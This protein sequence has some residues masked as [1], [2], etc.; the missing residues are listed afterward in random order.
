MTDQT[1]TMPPEQS[2]LLVLN[3]LDRCSWELQLCSTSYSALGLALNS[4]TRKMLSR[5]IAS[6]ISLLNKS[7]ELLQKV[8]ATPEASPSSTE[9]KSSTKTPALGDFRTF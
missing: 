1:K 8:E 3:S 5:D 9:K 4:E 2:L 7:L 6:V